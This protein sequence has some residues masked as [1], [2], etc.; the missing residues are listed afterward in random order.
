MEWAKSRKGLA[1]NIPNTALEYVITQFHVQ[2]SV[3]FHKSV[4]AL[5]YAGSIYITGR[6]KAI[7]WK[8]MEL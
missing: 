2:Y 1:P 3:L 7:I 6:T 5:G 8:Y 4:Q